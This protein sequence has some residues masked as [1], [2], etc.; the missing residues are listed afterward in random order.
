MTCHHDS[1]GKTQTG[2]L[3]L[4]CLAHFDTYGEVE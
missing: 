4:E 2:Y 3:C 1:L